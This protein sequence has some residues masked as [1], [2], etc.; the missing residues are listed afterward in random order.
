MEKVNWR[1]KGRVIIA[2][3][4]GCFFF[5]LG[6]N[7]FLVPHKLISGGISGVSLMIYYLTGYPL[8]TV[9]MILNIPVMWATWKWLGRWHVIVTIFG[10]TVVSFFLNNLSFL[11]SA[12]LTANPIVGA[13]LGGIFSG[14]GL[15]IMYREGGNSGGLDPIALII[16]NK[17]GLQMGSILLAI[18]VVVLF[19]GALIIN[20]ESAAITLISIYLSAMVTN[21]VVTGFNQRKAVFIISYKPEQVCDLIIAKVGRGATILNGQGAYTKQPKQ[22]ILAVVGL[23]QVAKL[24]D[25]IQKE[26]PSAFMLITDAAEVIGAGFTYKIN[27]VIEQSEVETVNV[28]VKK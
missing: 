6:A 19:F 9:N 2:V 28:E 13:M 24:K 4:V 5:A 26:D 15:G 20:V 17:Y 12:E 14:I 21:K 10:T 11:Q 25:L 7:A 8:G 3:I 27:E 18:N 1:D 23:L 22:V 16:R